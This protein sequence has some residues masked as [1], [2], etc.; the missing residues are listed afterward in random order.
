V[1]R[2]PWR[3]GTR[4]STPGK[5]RRSSGSRR[6][7]AGEVIDLAEI[8]DLREAGFFQQQLLLV[9][10]LRPALGDRVGDEIFRVRAVAGEPERT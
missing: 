10:Q 4:T 2:A 7:A 9:D 5:I 3:R 1:R 8:L 6:W